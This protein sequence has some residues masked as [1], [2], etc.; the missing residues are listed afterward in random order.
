MGG[1]TAAVVA[2]RGAGSIRGL[3]LV[4]P[5]FL[6]PER[7]REVRDS[8]VADQ[9][10]RALG[11]KKSDLVAQARARH[12]H[13]PPEIVELQAEAR[14][15][16][17]MGAFDVLTPPNPEYRDVVSAI[18]VPSLLIIGDSPVV[19]L[20]MATELRSLNPRVR[21]EQVQDSGHGLPFEQPER[22]GAIV[23]SFLRQ[24][25]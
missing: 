21:I 8:D 14:L 22:L 20:E 3:I 13:R 1:M 16:T 5:T 17:R 12:P 18:D 9:H 19:T 24:L 10:R 11:R 25:A 23:V 6:S 15:K 4:D 7:Q 2:N